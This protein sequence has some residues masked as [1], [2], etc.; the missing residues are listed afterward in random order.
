MR[1]TDINTSGK[2]N[3]CCWQALLQRGYRTMKQ[4]STNNQLISVY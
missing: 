4:I 1:E 2:N 3:H